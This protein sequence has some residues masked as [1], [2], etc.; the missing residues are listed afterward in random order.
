MFGKG[1]GTSK[2][3]HNSPS[4][5]AAKIAIRRNVLATVGDKTNVFDA[6]AG[7]GEMYAAVWKDAGGYTGCDLK[8]QRDGRLM[9]CAD[10]RRVMRAIDLSPF[11]VFDFDAFG[12]PWEVAIIMAARRKVA[13]GELIGVCLTD[14]NGL[15]YRHNNVP[16][17]MRELAGLANR[18]TGLGRNLDGAINRAIS[19]LCRR[20]NCTLQKRWQA[21]GKS[22][23]RVL[24]IGLVL[25][26]TGE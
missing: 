23:T 26:G 12:L 17:A 25:K 3:Q 18:V 7:T 1:A 11:N 6:F 22:G 5:L 19:G 14:G 21:E 20:M 4:A 9:F 2:Q 8:P 24:Y 10:N 15:Q 16:V 13:K